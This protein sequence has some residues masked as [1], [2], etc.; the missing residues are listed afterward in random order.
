MSDTKQSKS[1]QEIA[2]EQSEDD[3]GEV[4]SSLGEGWGFYQI[5]L[6]ILL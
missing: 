5:R 2:S 4:V 1:A 6:L 3:S